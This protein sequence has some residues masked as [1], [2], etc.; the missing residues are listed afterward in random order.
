MA[1]GAVQVLRGVDLSV[2]EGESVAIIGPSGSGKS[3]LLR[4]L[5]R[6][7]TPTGGTVTF[8]GK[9]I[10]EKSNVNH[11][12]QRMGMVFQHFNLFP[13][14]TAL[15]NV[16][17]APIHVLKMSRSEAEARGRDL[18]GR[19]GLL[20]KADFYPRQLSGGQKQRVA[21]ARCLAMNPRLLLLDEITSAL[22]PE[23]VGEVLDVV[24]DLARQGMTMMLVTHEMRFAREVADRVVF[25]DGGV[26]VEAGP[27]EEI[28]T[29]PKSPRLQK[30]LKA[31]LEQVSEA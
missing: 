9:P 13:H 11:L 16:I 6:L 26:V 30:F 15:G 3:T 25:M 14:M 19:V 17:E 8:E 28:F 20:E 31:V 4:C 12:R 18:L 24:R 23:L 10:T 21:I 7:E 2:R 27:P 29:R 5:N 22:D 1:F